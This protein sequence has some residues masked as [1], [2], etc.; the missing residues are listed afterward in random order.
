ME[1]ELL[2]TGVF[3]DDRYFDVVRRVRQGVARGHP[4]PD[5]GDQSRPRGGRAARAADAVVPQ[6]LVRGRR[7]ASRRCA[8]YARPDGARD[9]RRPCRRSASAA[10]TARATA[11][12][13]FTENETNNAAAV[14]HAPT[15][16]RTS[17]TVS[18]TT[19]CTASADAVNP[20]RRR[21]Q[22][23]GAL[24]ADDRRRASAP[25]AA[26]CGCRRSRPMP[27]GD[28]FGAASTRA[29]RDAH[30]ARPTS[31]IASITPAGGHARTRA[32]SCA[33]RWPGMLWS[34]QYYYFD[35]DT[36]LER[37]R[38]RI[39]CTPSGRPACATATGST[40]STTTSS[41]C[42][43]SG[44]IPWYAAWDLAFHTMA[45][46]HGGCRFRQAAARPDAARDATCTR[47]ARCRPT[48]GTSATSIRR[49]TPGRRSSCY[50]M[51]QAPARRRRR[52]V[53]EARLSA[54]CS[55]NF[56]WW[57]NRKDRDG[58]NVFEG[59]FLGLDNIGVFDR[60]APLPDRRLPRAGRRHRVDGAVL[61]EHAGDR[62]RA[63][64]RRSAYEDMAIK[65]VEHFLWIAARMNRIGP[66]RHVG[67]GGRVLLRRAAAARRQRATRL[68]VRSHG[69]AAAALR[70]D[71]HR[72]VA[73]RAR[74]RRRAHVRSERLR[75]HAGAAATA[76][77]RPGRAIAAYGDRGISRSVNE[78]RLR[79]IL[80]RM[81]D[82]NEFLSPLRHPLAVALP[83]RASLRVRRSAGQEYRV[84][85]L[86]A[87]SDTGMFGGNSNWRG[88]IWMPG[89]R[90]ADPRPAAVL[91]VLRRHVQGRM[92]DRLRPHDEPVRGRAA[93]S[94][95]A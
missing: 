76:S 91:P 38:R 10:C 73:A 14:R 1:Y 25:G 3:D 9:R 70:H 46:S 56:T 48:S 16:R 68:K 90:P 19:S 29:V 95:T 17:R 49:C 55:L 2:D 36:W 37:A 58:K 8:P 12:L 59:G 21:H 65:F 43:T 41:R 15:P 53:P 92:P 30:R 52:R 88:P 81:L 7:R 77:I 31:S 34:K 69:R 39:R 62:R 64:G 60:S 94:P 89:Q 5:H 50:R 24:P 27:I 33:R 78:Q 74:A 86:P 51:E 85:Y 35:V 23:G 11:A 67:R 44:S 87:E 63:R 6:H 45:L 61:P 40:W 54:S 57:V 47:T 79:R 18:T 75:A 22:G 42:R 32:T 93:R 28:P 72:A 20:A 84:D 26:R 4:D 80:A 13:L 71:G 82:E 83:R 66:G